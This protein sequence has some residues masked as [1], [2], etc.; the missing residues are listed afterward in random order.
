MSAAVGSLFW[1]FIG[2]S[3]L[4][5]VTPGPDMALVTRNALAHGPRGVILTTTGIALALALWVTAGAVGLAALLR[6]SATL[7]EVLK[8]AGGGYLAYLG[9]RAW[10]DSRRLPGDL[11]AGAPPAAPAGSILR[12]GFISAGSNPKLGV[13][14]VTFLPQFTEPGRPLLGQLVL[15]GAVFALIGWSWMNVYGLLVVR[16]RDWITAPRVRR[17]MER[18]TGTVLIGLGVRLALER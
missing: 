17:W 3:L 4:L 5:A 2:I 14:F 13:F 16:V 6:A 7:F 11:L 9:I 12:Q 1:A 18:L 10:L 8:L 15:L